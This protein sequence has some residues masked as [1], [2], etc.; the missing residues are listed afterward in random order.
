M[1]SF[2]LFVCVHKKLW[3]FIFF[4]SWVS[5]ISTSYSS[6]SQAQNVNCGTSISFIIEI[7]MAQ[8][9]SSST[10]A[11]SW[12][13]Y[14][15]QISCHYNYENDDSLTVFISEGWSSGISTYLLDNVI[16]T[17]ACEMYLMYKL[18]GVEL[19][20]LYLTSYHWACRSIVGSWFFFL[21]LKINNRKMKKLRNC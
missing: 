14:S 8:V 11:V 16:M 12:Y 2:F 21:H 15:I 19:N 5:E 7:V 17:R 6:C 1:W 4:L 3:F 13:H 9:T 20:Y 18:L 10:L